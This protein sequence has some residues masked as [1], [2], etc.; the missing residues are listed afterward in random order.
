MSIELMM[1]SNHLNLCP[2]LLL[3]PSAFHSIRVFSNESGFCIRWP[4]YWGFSISP[5]EQLWEI[6]HLRGKPIGAADAVE[7]VV[8]VLRE[9]LSPRDSLYHRQ[10]VREEDTFPLVAGQPSVQLELDR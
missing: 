1:P 7:D 10:E 4:K 6:L 5:S 8:A 3:L 9:F 2:P